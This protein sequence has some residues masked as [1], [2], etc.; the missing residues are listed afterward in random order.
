MDWLSGLALSFPG[1]GYLYC[2]SGLAILACL[3]GLA[4]KISGLQSGLAV[5]F[6][7]AY[8]GCW[9][10]SLD[11]AVQKSY[12]AWLSGLAISTG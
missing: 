2:L 7:Y 10:G 4:L 9:V 5:W 11:W 3:S 6:G 8:L 12:L 1:C